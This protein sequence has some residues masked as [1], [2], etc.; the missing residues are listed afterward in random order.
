VR[1][2]V[3]GFIALAQADAAIGQEVNIST[4]VEHT[5]AD[6]ART[7]ISAVNPEARIVEKEERLRPEKSEVFRLLGDNRKIRS[8]TSWSPQYDLAAGLLETVEWFRR[9]ENLSRYKAWIYNL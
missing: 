4:G 6:V 1:D 8:M 9:P 7:L 2:T 3:D 5:I